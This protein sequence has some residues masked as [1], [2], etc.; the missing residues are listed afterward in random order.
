MSRSEPGLLDAGLRVVGN[1]FAMLQ[2]RIELASL[3]LGEAGD[4]LV[5]AIIASFAVV[6]LV[7]GA[8]AA[9]SA[10]VAAA[11]WDSVGLAVLGWLALAY[12]A[13][14]AVL[15]VWLRAQL[16]DAPTPLAETLAEL[17]KDVAAIRGETAPRDPRA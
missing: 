8:L 12:G 2:N 5:T 6:L 17:A 13:A 10:W 1:V 15:I 9:L 14:A 11:L 7:F 4:R 3:E 16:R